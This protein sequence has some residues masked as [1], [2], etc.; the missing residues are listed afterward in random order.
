M[1]EDFTTKANQLSKRFWELREIIQ[2]EDKSLVKK[3]K[4]QIEKLENQLNQLNKNNPTKT[5]FRQQNE[6][7][8]SELE[9][10]EKTKINLK[11]IRKELLEITKYYFT[12]IPSESKL[13]ELYIRAITDIL[14]GKQKT[15]LEL[16]KFKISSKE[17][18]IEGEDEADKLIIAGNVTIFIKEAAKQALGEPSLLKELQERIKTSTRLKLFYVFAKY[19]KPLTVDKIKSII[20]ESEWD[21][22]K[23]NDIIT[24]LLRDNRF[25]HKIIH[26][27]GKK[28][29]YQQYQ[30]SDV[31]RILLYLFP[32]KGNEKEDKNKAQQKLTSPIIK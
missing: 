19:D 12:I 18:L 10:F 28:G 25:D 16:E 4:F 22:G 32:L 14:M 24:D 23:I 17:Y 21:V 31:G 29:Q 8:K 3:K 5:I 13:N 1:I 11:N 26:R 20:D 7:L 27:I 6:K 30:I 2:K 15:K 9:S